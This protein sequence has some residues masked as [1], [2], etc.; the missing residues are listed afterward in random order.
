MTRDAW[1]DSTSDLPEQDL[2]GRERR[3]ESVPSPGAQNGSARRRTAGCAAL[4]AHRGFFASNRG[5]AGDRSSSPCSRVSSRA[6]IAT[7]GARVRNR[8]CS[9]YDQ[10]REGRGDLFVVTRLGHYLRRRGYETFYFPPDAWHE[11]PGLEWFVSM[12]PGFRPSAL[13]AE[14][15]VVGWARNAFGAW[16]GHPGLERFQVILTSSPRFAEEAQKVYSG[17]I[18]L[19]P[20]GVDLELFEPPATWTS[21]RVGVVTTTNQWGGERDLYQALRSSRVDYPLDI[22]GQPVGL[23]PELRPHYLGPVDYFELPGIYWARSTGSVSWTTR[24][25]L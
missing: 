21:S 15:K 24:I 14:S 22:Y 8:V 16:L 10:L 12:L 19:L 3:Q 4:T 17:D 20:I 2:A 23:L 7:N 13:R 11:A 9:V 1:S 25:P 6:L 18:H 5:T